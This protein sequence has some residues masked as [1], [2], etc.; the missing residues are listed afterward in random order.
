MITNIF[1]FQRPYQFH[2]SAIDPGVNNFQASQ[3]CFT[4]SRSTCI[5]RGRG[6]SRRL[7]ELPMASWWVGRGP[8]SPSGA[9]VVPWHCAL[10]GVLTSQIR[11]KISCNS[12][13]QGSSPHKYQHFRWKISC[14]SCIF[15][16]KSEKAGCSESMG[17][18]QRWIIS[19]AG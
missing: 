19:F 7:A 13:L 2:H 3:A 17:A 14:N 11:L 12:H 18:A 5:V 16:S 15:F 6:R 1:I 8:S 10:T 9:R 4:K